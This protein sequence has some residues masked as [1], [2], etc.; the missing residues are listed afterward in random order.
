MQ[1]ESGL[2]KVGKRHG[3]QNIDGHNNRKFTRY[4]MIMCAHS[5]SGK[6][7]VP[8]FDLLFNK[9]CQFSAFVNKYI[10]NS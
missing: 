1:G 8:R 4:T 3:N 9:L 7:L 6:S 10:L 5:Y 2:K